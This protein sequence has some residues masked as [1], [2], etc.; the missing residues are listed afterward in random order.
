MAGSIKDKAR[1]LPAGSQGSGGPGMPDTGA[2]RAPLQRRS[3]SS[4]LELAPPR[5]VSLGA[6]RVA[7]RREERGELHE[8]G[9]RLGEPGA[10]REAQLP[11]RPIAEHGALVSEYPL[12]APPERWRFP[13]RNR[14]ISGLSLGTLVVEAARHSGSPSPGRIARTYTMQYTPIVRRFA[15]I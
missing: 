1:V 3:L 9:R 12:G 4:G 11:R 10:R 8:H 13:E 6:R 2:R 14:L 15:S 7:G 5:P